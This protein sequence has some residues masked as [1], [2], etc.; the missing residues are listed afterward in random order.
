MSR[1][2]KLPVAIPQGV[3]CSVTPTEIRVKGKLGELFLPITSD[4][5]VEITDGVVQVSAAN[6][7]T[8]SRSMWGTVRSILVNMVKGVTTGFIQELEINGVGYRASVSGKTLNLALGYSHDIKYIL[9]KDVD[10]KVD[11]NIITISGANKQ[12]VGQIAAELMRLRPFEP[13][14]GKGVFKK[15]KPGPRK[16]GKKK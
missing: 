14:K 4:V 7:S 3:E 13:Y 2:G 16:E 5:H 9:P 11:K 10:V 15:G 8:F 1:V 6:S 12:K